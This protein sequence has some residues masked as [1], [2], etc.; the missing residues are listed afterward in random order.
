MLR[1]NPEVLD[2]QRYQKLRFFHFNAAPPRAQ[3]GFGVLFYCLF[4]KQRE[5]G[6]MGSGIHQMVFHV[7]APLTLTVLFDRT[8]GSIRIGEATEW[9]VSPIP[10]HPFLHSQSLS[11]S[12]FP[13]S[14]SKHEQ[15]EN[16]PG[17]NGGHLEII[18]YQPWQRRILNMLGTK[19]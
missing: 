13:S 15:R 5:A 7:M 4:F 10:C 19:L 9:G 11:T 3:K 2:F 8:H 12:L 17:G 18:Q 16:L 14:S 1:W 6:P